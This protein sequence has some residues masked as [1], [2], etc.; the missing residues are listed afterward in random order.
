MKYILL[1]VSLLAFGNMPVMAGEGEIDSLRTVVKIGAQDTNTVNA[2]NLL[3]KKYWSSEQEKALEYGNSALSL[4]Q[5]IKYKKGEAQ[6]LNNIGVTYYNFSDY[7]KALENHFKALELRE[8]LGDKKDISASLNNIGNAYDG[9]SDYSN[10]LKF[11]KKALALKEEI[12]DEKG[13]ANT[14]NN[15]GNLYYSLGNYYKAL[16]YFFIALKIY[17]EKDEH[18]EA[19]ANTLH[20][21]GNVYKEQKD[22]KNAFEFY[23]KAL[24]MRETDED[25]Q[26]IG[27]SYTSIAGLHLVSAEEQKNST[28]AEKDYAAA[29]E[30]YRKALEIQNKID[31]KANMAISLNNIGKIYLHEGK[32]DSALVSSLSA[33]MMSEDIGDISTSAFSM[34]SLADVYQKQKNVPVSSE[35]AMKALALADS[36]RILEIIKTANKTLSEN[37]ASLN[38]HE[39]SLEHYKLYVDYRDSLLNAE[40]AKE[41]ANV[42]Q[43]YETEKEKI[44]KERAR[45]A[46]EEEHHR[47]EQAQYLVIVSIIIIVLMF[48]VIASHMQLSAKTIDYAAFVGVLLFFQFLEVMLHP[49][50]NHYAH[51]LPIVFI[52]INIALISTLKPIHHYVEKGLLKVS[53]NIMHRKL[54]L[55]ERKKAEADRKRREMELMQSQANSNTGNN[56]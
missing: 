32:Y 55:I 16:E 41:M 33:L 12:G 20:N 6:A 3:C 42:Q 2:L 9:L 25:E 27:E 46:E 40:N 47:V 10:E 23:E 51:G 52:L 36:L 8:K 53:H 1:F 31:D 13:I 43:K 38:Q 11:F 35:Y 45:L 49:I 4:A 39:K 5:K 56:S 50:I 26:G 14:S 19:H 37:Y 15:I 18:S 44:E 28:Y 17:D 54:Q 24:K 34:G 21:I 7:N 30:Y 48:I 29:K 22:N